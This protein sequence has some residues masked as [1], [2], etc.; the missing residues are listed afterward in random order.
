MIAA[1]SGHPRQVHLPPDWKLSAIINDEY[2]C[3]TVVSMMRA[4]LEKTVSLKHGLA[5]RDKRLWANSWKPSSWQ[6]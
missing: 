3:E 4:A 6:G 5:S 1:V 2:Y